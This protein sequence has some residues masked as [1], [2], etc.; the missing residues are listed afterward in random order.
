MS[1]AT[2]PA[3]LNYTVPCGQIAKAKRIVDGLTPA[4]QEA[5]WL[6]QIQKEVIQ[7]RTDLTQVLA[8]V[9]DILA[10]A[11]QTTTGQKTSDTQHLDS[12]ARQ[13]PPA[14]TRPFDEMAEMQGPMEGLSQQLAALLDTMKLRALPQGKHAVTAVSEAPATESQDD[15]GERQMPTPSRSPSPMRLARP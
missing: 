5:G 7:L 15:I 11:M 10:I 1:D 14:S 4:K 12:T 8:T 13:L 6:T 2:F 9:Q 3:A